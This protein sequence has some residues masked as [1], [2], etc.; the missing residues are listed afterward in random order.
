MASDAGYFHSFCAVCDTAHN[1]D[2]LYCSRKCQKVEIGSSKAAADIAA[3]IKASGLTPATGS[4]SGP[5][6]SA[7]STRPKATTPTSSV[8]SLSSLSIHNSST[9]S[10]GYFPAQKSPAL[11]ESF[12]SNTYSVGTVTDNH[13]SGSATTLLSTSPVRDRK[14]PVPERRSTG[15]VAYPGVH[16]PSHGSAASLTA[17]ALAQAE[18]TSTTSSIQASS[19]RSMDKHRPLPLK[20]AS[21]SGSLPK[22]TELVM[23]LSSLTPLTPACSAV[24]DLNSEASRASHHRSRS[25]ERMSGHQATS[26]RELSLS[27][28]R[29]AAAG[30]TSMTKP[31]A[32]PNP[33]SETPDA[34]KLKALRYPVLP[35]GSRF[36]YRPGSTSSAA[37]N[38]SAS[39]ATPIGPSNVSQRRASGASDE[40]KT[41]SDGR[42]RKMFFFKQVQS[43]P[44]M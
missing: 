23:P 16:L 33:A 37:S 20:R 26:A 25:G 43:D 2:S 28:A 9:S 44:A 42:L 11:V 40:T 31:V 24:P 12:S 19:R 6:S 39:S 14:L 34:E 35:A 15:P 21:L 36:D 41:A 1:R 30:S 4:T 13:A 5:N 3:R 32:A 8:A 17:L 10:L 29:A 27:A 18:P 22:S 38:S 7:S